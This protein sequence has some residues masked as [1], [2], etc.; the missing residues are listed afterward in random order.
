MKN[1]GKAAAI[2]GVCFLLIFV[3]VL[4]FDSLSSDWSSGAKKRYLFL[5]DSAIFLSGVIWIL[6]LARFV[7]KKFKET[8]QNSRP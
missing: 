8:L 7:F 4:V 2:S 3:L 5:S 6:L 1:A